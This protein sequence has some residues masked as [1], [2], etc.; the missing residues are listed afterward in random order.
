MASAW[1]ELPPPQ[2]ILMVNNLGPIPLSISALLGDWARRRRGRP[3]P[4][5]QS[6]LALFLWPAVYVTTRGG[7]STLPWLTLLILPCGSQ[8]R[9]T[10]C[11][12]VRKEVRFSGLGGR[13]PLCPSTKPL[14]R[15]FQADTYRHS[16]LPHLHT[17]YGSRKLC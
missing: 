17:A 7:R 10:G 14:S 11:F 16:L 9:M 2:K 4:E 1:Q 6:C 13:G 5:G 8:G 15:E 3:N 12:T